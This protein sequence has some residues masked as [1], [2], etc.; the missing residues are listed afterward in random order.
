M[1]AALCAIL[2]AALALGQDAAAARGERVFA[3]NCS[4][5]YC[6]GANGTAGRAPKLAGHSFTTRELAN[7][8]SDGIAPKGMPAFGKQL[9]REDLDA[10]VTY[11]MTLRANTAAVATA[12]A[13]P[14][15]S[16]MP[17]KALFFDAV[18]MGGC[19]RCHELDRRG[20]P[21][22]Q[23]IKNVPVDLRTVAATLTVTVSPK[24]ERS[25]PGIVLERSEK[26]VRVYDLSSPLPVLRTFARGDVEVTSGSNWSHK[27]AAAGY[28]DAELRT[29]AEFLQSTIRK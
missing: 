18:R 9:S 10:V 15:A 3:A 24:G 13:T 7:T 14:R 26:R 19:G 6:H 8:V 23:S 2:F 20:S 5:P 12:T 16:E 28:S 22:A 25:F 11:L 21:V 1:K 17:G 29:I 4:V 27:D